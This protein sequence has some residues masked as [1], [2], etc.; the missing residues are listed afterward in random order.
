MQPSRSIVIRITH[1]LV[2][3]L[4]AIL[5][6]LA[7]TA[8]ARAQTGDELRWRCAYDAVP[9]PRVA[10]RLV[11]WPAGGAQPTASADTTE[12][13][14]PMLT[15]IR[16]APETLV[17]ERIVIPLHAPPVDMRF[18]ARLA[19]AVMCGPRAD[20]AVDFSGDPTED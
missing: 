1:S 3:V 15:R 12:A 7:A 20:C 11:R 17:D 2:V 10:C 16:K 6:S 8:T 5:F 18:V 14:T 19:H 9:G 13:L 4:V